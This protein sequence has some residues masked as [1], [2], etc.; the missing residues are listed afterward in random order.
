MDNP[1]TP[2]PASKPLDADPSAS[3][4][5]VPAPAPIKAEQIPDVST[6][7]NLDR[8]FVVM[9]N[10]VS[11]YKPIP[12]ANSTATPKPVSGAALPPPAPLADSGL[13]QGG[14]A[15]ATDHYAPILA[16]AKYPYKFCNKT[17]MQAVATASFDAGKFW[18][19]EW[20]L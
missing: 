13:Q 16:L 12:M 19:R 2:T 6:P 11:A 18:N 4:K 14:L 8:R 7:A 10:A 5:A 9:E 17:D 20:D 15:S 3:P 1:P